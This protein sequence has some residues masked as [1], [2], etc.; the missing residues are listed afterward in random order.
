MCRGW[1]AETRRKKKMNQRDE[2]EKKN[3]FILK[4][5]ASW[6]KINT[7]ACCLDASLLTDSE[8]REDRTSAFTCYIDT[9]SIHSAWGF[10][11]FVSIVV[12]LPCHETI[13]AWSLPL[14]HRPVPEIE[15]A[16]ACYPFS[17]ASL[18]FS[19]LFR[20][21]WWQF[22]SV[23]TNE[24]HDYSI[25]FVWIHSSPWPFDSSF[26]FLLWCWPSFR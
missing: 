23:W 8:L 11:L 3:H 1:A 20:C 25:Q 6:S 22:L 17:Y 19:S 4:L 5:E 10:D 13:D 7:I 24:S 16:F 18:H 9:G 26:S 15:P 2:V 12:T 21:K 14:A